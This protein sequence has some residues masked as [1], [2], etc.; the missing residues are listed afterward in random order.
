MRDVESTILPAAAKNHN[1]LSVSI[2]GSVGRMRAD[3]LKLRQML[4][5]VLSNACK[6]TKN[7]RVSLNVDTYDQDGQAW[8]LFEVCDTGIGIAKD[9]LERLFEPFFQGDNTIRRRFGGAGLGLALTKNF[10]EIMGGHISV[11]S[12]L[13]KG[14]ICRICLPVFSI[15]IPPV[16]MMG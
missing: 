2:S 7:G 13:G 4:L 10:C 3:A 14:T 11:K 9:H 1:E 8:I 16:Q 15:S 5:N 6:F 12:E